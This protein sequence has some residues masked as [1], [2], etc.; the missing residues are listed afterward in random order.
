MTKFSKLTH[1]LAITGAAIAGFAMTPAG[2]A[3]IHQYPKLSP[4]LA[5]VLTIA[6]IYRDPKAA[7]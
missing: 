4:V 1:V 6:G 3:I 7:A 5:A 2:Q